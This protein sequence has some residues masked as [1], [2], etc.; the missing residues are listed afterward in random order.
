MLKNGFETFI[1]CSD[2]DSYFGT[3]SNAD[4]PFG[5]QVEKR[6]GIKDR[7]IAYSSVNVSQV[8]QLAIKRI[9]N[10][11]NISGKDCEGLVL[12]SSNPGHETV[13]EQLA[14]QYEIPQVRSV[15]YACSGFP[16]AV[17]AALEMENPSKRHILVITAEILSQLVDWSDRDTALV[18][19][20][21]VAITSVIPGGKHTI[22]DAWARGNIVDP[23]K[24]LR[25]Q[26]RT[27]TLMIE[28]CN[29]EESEELGHAYKTVLSENERDII[30]M[31][32]GRHLFK[33][34]PHSLLDIVEHV[35]VGIEG[36]NRIVP[37]QANGR[38]VDLMNKEIQKKY[39]GRNIPIV[40][41]IPHQA[42]SASASIGRGIAKT[43]H[44]Y[45][46]GEV[47]ACPAKGAGIYYEEGK[48]TEGIVLFE[49]G[50]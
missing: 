36:V 44:T 37:H 49:V 21:G 20:D 19:G 4:H 3:L 12:S 46:P 18:F 35:R 13:A 1:D 23:E 26:R 47:V 16:A 6:T 45:T 40:N 8:S 32:G 11:L 29:L 31:D 28:R 10:E 34:V 33:T 38:F 30:V 43:I 50:K 15:N 25:M 27:G 39:K 7:K 2:D 5:S 17:Q 24:C 48:L 22:K 42:N 14:K 41:T 9:F